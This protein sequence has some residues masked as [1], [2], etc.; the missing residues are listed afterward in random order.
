MD[1][2]IKLVPVPT[3]NPGSSISAVNGNFI[4]LHKVV[5]STYF[6]YRKDSTADDIKL[7]GE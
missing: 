4:N 3:G 6:Q 5:D 1:Q 2:N 7:I